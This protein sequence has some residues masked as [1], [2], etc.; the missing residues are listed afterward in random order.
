MLTALLVPAIVALGALT[1]G[2]TSM[3]TAHND[4][5]RSVD[6]GSAAGAAETPAAAVTPGAA[7]MPIPIDGTS[8][9]RDLSETL[10][11]GDWKAKPCAVAQEQ[12]AGARSI[13]TNAFKGTGDQKTCTATWTHESPTLAAVSACAADLLDVTSCSANLRS[14]LDSTLPALSSSDQ[15]ITDMLAKAK[16][17]ADSYTNPADKLLDAA[18]AQ[19]LPG[20]CTRVVSVLTGLIRTTVCDQTVSSLL[21]P[22]LGTVTGT[23]GGATSGVCASPSGQPIPCV[24]LD[25]MLPA[26]LTPRVK[27]ELNGAELRPTFSPFTFGLNNSATARRT[28]KSA[29]VLPSAMPAVELDR[30]LDTRFGGAA[31]T[32]QAA[33]GPNGWVIDPNILS[34]NANAAIDRDL[35]RLDALDLTDKV[36]GI[37]GS[38][39]FSAFLS[40]ACTRAPMSSFCGR[41][42]SVA[43]TRAMRG[44]FIQDLRDATRPPPQG[45]APSFNEMLDTLATS[46]DPVM[47]V[48][49]LRP[50]NLRKF[51]GESAWS[52]L[53]DPSINPVLAPLLSEVMYMPALDVVPATVGRVV[54]GGKSYYVLHDLRAT[55]NSVPWSDTLAAKG[56][57]Q[58]RLVK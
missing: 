36:D 50:K 6:L 7:W 55:A 46:G 42:D 25:G 29:L 1:L 45:A 54:I 32:L 5:Q 53:T 16:Q 18:T 44:Q 43:A 19:Q 49:S 52:V 11:P 48:S 27:V 56:L 37:V 51:L 35:E 17:V 33:A 31:L 10:D 57:F 38:K 12:L 24:D 28:I 26:A 2:V 34:R 30:N 15:G 14:Q 9:T 8:V 41:V 13:V 21:G 40:A 58:A 47:V 3:W 23:T 39:L 20:G 22:Y 4:I